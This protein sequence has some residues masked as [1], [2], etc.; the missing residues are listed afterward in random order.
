MNISFIIP[1]VDRITSLD[2]LLSTFATQTVIPDE[3]IIVEQGLDSSQQLSGKYPTLP[4]RYFHVSFRSLTSARNFGVSKSAGE[5][6]GFL[7]DDVL[8][9]NNYVK[10]I[11]SFFERHK[12]ALGVQGVITNFEEGHREKVG[13]SVIVYSLYNI[14]AKLFLLNNS[15]NKNK[16]L[17]SGRNQYASRVAAVDTCEWLSGIGNYRRSVFSEFNFDET[18]KGYALGEDKLFSY[19]IQKKYPHSLYVDPV[20]QCEHHSVS[21]G[22]PEAER[23]VH[24]KITYTYYL[25]EKLFATKGVVALAAYWWAN[26]GDI[27]M[28]ILSVILRKNTVL[29]LWWHVR[30]YSCLLWKKPTYN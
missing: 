1:T 3:I 4:I 8:L 22:K 14:L 17:L 28:V 15:S 9:N 12:T 11:L 13:G 26:V 7:D 19:P 27:G 5:I 20:I 30:E 18:L 25:W 2:A 16:L 10:G 6:I 29:F 23:W 24:M 21:K